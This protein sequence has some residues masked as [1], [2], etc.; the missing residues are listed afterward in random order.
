MELEDALIESKK[1]KNISIVGL[2]GMATFTSNKSL[3]D[4][5][6]KFLKSIYDRYKSTY[7]NFKILSMGMSGDYNTAIS[8][9]SNMIRVGSK[10]FG[11]RI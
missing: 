4:S 10:I 1:M 5:E 8:N 11:E 9:G 3:I 7:S 2:M 6:F